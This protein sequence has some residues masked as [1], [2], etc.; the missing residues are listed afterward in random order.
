MFLKASAMEH[1]NF[2]ETKEG[3]NWMFWKKFAKDSAN[4]FWNEGMI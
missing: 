2:F 4:F 3:H 1:A